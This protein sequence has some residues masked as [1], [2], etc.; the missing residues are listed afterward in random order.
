MRKVREFLSRMGLW[1]GDQEVPVE[2]S[3]MSWV[4]YDR[5]RRSLRICFKSGNIYEYGS[6]PPDLFRDFLH[7][8]S[9]GRFFG[10]VIRPEFPYRKITA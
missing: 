2:S 1:F 7:A 5:S 4:R 3:V 10:K 9:K 8:E 6:F